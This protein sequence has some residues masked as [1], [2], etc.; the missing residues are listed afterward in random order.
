MKSTLLSGRRWSVWPWD[1]ARLV[2]FTI[3]AA[4]LMPMVLAAPRPELATLFPQQAEI[5][6]GDGVSTGDAS[7][8]GESTD[9]G[10]IGAG[11]TDADSRR[12][13]L[14]R[15]V[16]PTEVVRAVRPDLSDLRVFDGQGRQV[17]YLV[18]AGGTRAELREEVAAV[19]LEV[20]RRTTKEA[21]EGVT[22]R[23][24]APAI[25]RE[26]YEIEVPSL[27]PA[28]GS[29][30]LVFEA[31]RRSFVRRL[32]VES[33]D[34]AGTPR[35]LVPE[36]SL[37]RLQ[38]PLREKRRVSL[39]PLGGNIHRLR[40][41][42]E[43]E[44]GSYLDPKIR[45][46]SR[47]GF[48]ARLLA[49]SE[50][51]ELG[52]KTTEGQTVIELERPRGLVADRLRLV[53][54]TEA[55]HRQVAVWDEG[56]GSTDGVLG[57]EAC[58]RVLGSTA[59]EGLEIELSPSRGDRL[60]VVIADGDSPPLENLSFL[61]EVRQPALIFSL[62]AV[63]SGEVVGTL[64]FGGGRAFRPQYDVAALLPPVGQEVT[65]D[66]AEVARRLYDPRELQEARLGEAESNPSFDP[67][68][69]LAFAQRPGAVLDA[70]P[71]RLRRR[72]QA[73]PSPEGLVRL[74]LS[75][76][77]LAE[78][79]PDLA[80]IRILGDEDKQW[81][82][83]LERA[84]ARETRSLALLETETKDGRSVY[85]IGLPAEDVTL[86]RVTLSFPEPFFDREFSLVGVHEKERRTLVK[87]RLERRIGDPRPVV[88]PF[89]ATRLDALEL[90][91]VD[92]D[93]APLDL[94]TVDARLPVAELFFAGPEGNYTLLL[95]NP[96]DS[97][98]R[99][100]LERVRD[101]VL[102]VASGDA[103]VSPLQENPSFRS[104]SRL[105]TVKGAQQILLWGA[106]G[107]AVLLLTF[108][109]FRLARKEEG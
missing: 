104:H 81:A 2:L 19:V 73:R 88:V 48:D 43:G 31:S 87:G 6:L 55:F 42:L 24:R 99:Y 103:V 28:V 61:A 26:V 1:R 10:S 94:A 38:S 107:A 97:Q 17:P 27:K 92:G 9:A 41:I 32:V 14:T 18:D 35:V 105:G 49:S 51:H 89:Q 80:D 58:F 66:R 60:R 77:D 8:E 83:L 69:I 23:D 71:Y 4:L 30:D 13:G 33:L 95:G 67:A 100:E 102:A 37:F 96:E 36:A 59:V 79:R 25:W 47:Q 109:T 86:T 106:L 78:A 11:S 3:G 62:P 16:L 84:G 65:G 90:S 7:A 15:L 34:R 93:D 5:L 74:L 45:F 85:R 53:T 40:V 72:F 101:V 54:T 46:L 98:P 52:R 50:L 75:V 76:E 56:P 64:R 21:S 44:E 108:L 63:A 12:G 39:P 82:Y 91:I 57:K 22:G 20:A 68:P 29:W 70:R